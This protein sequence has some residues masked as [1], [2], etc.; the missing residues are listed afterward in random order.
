[1]DKRSRASLTYRIIT[2]VLG[3]ALVFGAY[4]L[5]TVSNY[6]ALSLVKNLALY[7]IVFAALV[8]IWWRL[9]SFFEM[10]ILAGKS[11]MIAGM[12]IAFNIALA[13][14]FLKLI[15]SDN[16]S[17]WGWAAA[18]L[19]GGVVI[20]T[21]L[22]AILV[23]RSSAYRSKAQWRMIH[24]GLW[25]TGGIFLAS[26]LVPLSVAPF[27]EFPARFL[28]WIL[29]LFTIPIYQQVAG[30]FAAN[31]APVRPAGSH[32]ATSASGPGLAGG[33]S[34]ANPSG[35]ASSN[36]DDRIHHHPHDRPP[37]RGGRGRFRRHSGSR[38]RM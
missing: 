3:L 4:A 22:M 17:I 5:S 11:G 33:S 25:L 15:I 16:E 13:P 27:A 24:H 32:P 19:T 6:T 12:V 30:R 28:L 7:A 31:P 21:A 34:S 26:L 38:R 2:E 8:A 37:R 20:I 18:F 36:S 9:S 23:Y 14:V 1:M 10:G 35:H 29:A